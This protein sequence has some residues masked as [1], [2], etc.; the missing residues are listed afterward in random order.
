MC[1]R[2]ALQMHSACCRTRSRICGPACTWPWRGGRHPASW[3]RPSATTSAMFLPPLQ[4]R[5][6]FWLP[7]LG[8][9]HQET[10]IVLAFL[11]VV[12]GLL[13]R[14]AEGVERSGWIRPALPSNAANGLLS[15]PRSCGDL[16]TASD[17][18]LQA[19][20]LSPAFSLPR[21][22]SLPDPVFYFV[23]GSACCRLR[24]DT[25]PAGVAQQATQ[26]TLSNT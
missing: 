22:L 11:L 24:L 10:G 1:P 6:L 16:S 26:A 15:A 12:T 21:L 14:I 9:R 23:D 18:P 4:S 8:A 5:S 3:I 7:L 2:M 19:S 17:M 13:Q 25:Q 20:C